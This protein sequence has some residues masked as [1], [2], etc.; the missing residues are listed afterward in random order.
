MDYENINEDEPSVVHN[1]YDYSNVVPTIESITYLAQYLSSVYKQFISLVEED[2]KKNE[3]FKEEYRHYSFKRMFSERFAI[4]I[5]QK[6]FSTITCKDFT[7]FQSAISDGNVNNVR[8]LDI[9]MQLDYRRGVGNNL[10]DHENLF[11]IIFKPYEITFTRKSSHNEFQMNQIEKDVKDIFSQI[12]ALNT[13]F[14][15]K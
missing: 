2:Q 10:V 14:C 8:S 7:S 4:T 9:V 11:H 13:I 5:M 12:P 15:T 6:S 1:E 3:Q